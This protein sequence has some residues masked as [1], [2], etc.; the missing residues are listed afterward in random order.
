MVTD[1][2]IYI[3]IY[4]FMALL[5]AY[6]S[7]TMLE[8]YDSKMKISDEAINNFIENLPFPLKL[9]YH[10]NITFHQAGKI[11]IREP[12]Y[13][14]RTIILVIL[15]MSFF[16]FGLVS[17]T[18]H[19]KSLV[20]LSALI[21]SVLTLLYSRCWKLRSMLSEVESDLSRDHPTSKTM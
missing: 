16:A 17:E 13:Y 19:K 1:N 12:S 15:I 5:V 14:L 8:Y 21:L 3:F 10:P 18:Y 6:L 7:S 4:F 2:L 20:S 11:F 9:F